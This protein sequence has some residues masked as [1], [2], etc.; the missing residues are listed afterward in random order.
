MLSPNT[1]SSP[2]PGE[3]LALVAI[4]VVLSRLMSVQMFRLCGEISF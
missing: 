1:D 4:V 3:K 2:A